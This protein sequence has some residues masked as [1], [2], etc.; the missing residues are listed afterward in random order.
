MQAIHN[1]CHRVGSFDERDDDVIARHNTLYSANIVT[2]TSVSRKIMPG[3]DDAP[4]TNNIV[5][6]KETTT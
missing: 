1:R 5:P 6:V 4:E 2:L 3:N